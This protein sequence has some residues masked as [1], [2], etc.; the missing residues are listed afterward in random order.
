MAI[1][2]HVVT[3]VLAAAMTLA[4][5][6][7]ATQGS[8]S[9]DGA[10]VPTDYLQLRFPTY[11][12][13]EIPS[14]TIGVGSKVAV[15]AISGHQDPPGY[16][17]SQNESV[18]RADKWPEPSQGPRGWYPFVAV[19][20]GQATIWESYPCSGTGCAAM[21]A[22]I[23]LT[24]VS[25]APT[26]SSV[27]PTP[28]PTPTAQPPTAQLPTAQLPTAQLPTAQLPMPTPSSGSALP[29]GPDAGYPTGS[30][31]EVLAVGS[32]ASGQPL[33]TL[34]IPDMNC[35]AMYFGIAAM[36]APSLGPCVVLFDASNGN[37]GPGTDPGI[38]ANA[39]CPPWP[40]PHVT[41]VLDPR[42]PT[43]G[44]E[45]APSVPSGLHRG[46]IGWLV[47]WGGLPYFALPDGTTIR[48]PTP[49]RA[50]RPSP[51]S[52]PAP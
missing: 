21:M 12:P 6:G 11:P 22:T 31:A 44:C 40:T 35:T 50:P 8:V 2:R 33:L 13:N 9:T 5:A 23:V 10:K 20:P 29:V 32:G 7:C 30:N 43:T 26:D 46:A 1:W 15:L 36:P 17:T 18:V 24:V 49:G 25:A 3:P 37:V 34:L 52:T 45:S 4:V 39:A 16:P 28:T 41:F 47:E 14:F 51:S 19:S 48:P 42:P 38:D 27:A